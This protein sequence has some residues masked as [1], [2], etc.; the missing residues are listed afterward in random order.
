MV[1]E[2][3]YALIHFLN[4]KQ[5]PRERKDSFKTIKIKKQQKTT[6]KEQ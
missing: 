3:S 6:T 2:A 5:E 4:K 1:R